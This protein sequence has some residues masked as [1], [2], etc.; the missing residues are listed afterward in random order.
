MCVTMTTFNSRSGLAVPNLCRET[1]MLFGALGLV[2]F[3]LAVTAAP[4]VSSPAASFSEE[5]YQK[6]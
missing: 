4:L 1:K 6:R 3:S 2:L 5:I